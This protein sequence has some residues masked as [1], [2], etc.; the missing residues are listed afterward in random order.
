MK[1]N[2]IFLKGVFLL[3]LLTLLLSVGANVVQYSQ[4]NQALQYWS[5]ALK[6]SKNSADEEELRWA[7]MNPVPTMC[8]DGYPDP[9]L[10]LWR[11]IDDQKECTE[12]PQFRLGWGWV[13][14]EYTEAC[15]G[16]SP[17]T[18]NAI[19][20][21][22]DS[23]DTFVGEGETNLTLKPGACV[24]V[25]QILPGETQTWVYTITFDPISSLKSTSTGGVSNVNCANAHAVELRMIGGKNFCYAVADGYSYHVIALPPGGKVLAISETQ[26]AGCEGNSAKLIANDAEGNQRVS[27]SIDQ[28]TTVVSIKD[29]LDLQSAT[30]VAFDTLE[31]YC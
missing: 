30:G 6:V 1:Q 9:Y 7:D 4:R 18:L 23:V 21:L 8:L 2:N 26:Q 14:T 31:I 3:M 11:S 5:Q 13:N 12:V 15:A 17:V 28:P 20:D 29:A 24:T 25:G 10:R 19:H 16:A 27:V 22:T